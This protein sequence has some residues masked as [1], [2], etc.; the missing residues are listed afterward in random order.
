MSEVFE[1]EKQLKNGQPFHGAC[2]QKHLKDVK[3]PLVGYYP[4]DADR[5]LGSNFKHGQTQ[6]QQQQ[7]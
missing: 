3:K 4:G 2:L 1:A 7:S 5:V 6:Q